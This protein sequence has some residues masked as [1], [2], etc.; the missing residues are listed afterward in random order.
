MAIRNDY[1]N[2]ALQ[3]LRPGKGERASMMLYFESLAV[4]IVAMLAVI[5]LCDVVKTIKGA[6]NHAKR[7]RKG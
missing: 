1:S 6:I 2:F 5:G 3:R 4:Y 7:T